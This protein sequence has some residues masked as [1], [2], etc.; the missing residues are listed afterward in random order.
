MTIR[1]TLAAAIGLSLI[2]GA[3]SAD[4]FAAY[5]GKYPADPVN[6]VGFFSHPKVEAGIKDAEGDAVYEE[7]SNLQVQ[8]PITG[9]SEV[10]VANVCRQHDCG[11]NNASVVMWRNGELA[12]ICRF[13]NNVEFWYTPFFDGALDVGPGQ[14]QPCPS[15]VGQMW[16]RVTDLGGADSM[17]RSLEM[18]VEGRARQQASIA[19]SWWMSYRHA[20]AQSATMVVS[21]PPD[22]FSFQTVSDDKRGAFFQGADGRSYI[23]AYSGFLDHNTNQTLEQAY[24]AYRNQQGRQEVEVNRPTQ[25]INYIHFSA[26][27]D[28]LIY[29]RVRED[30]NGA[31]WIWIEAQIPAQTDAATADM[32]KKITQTFKPDP[33]PVD[34]CF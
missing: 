20:P 22:R 29:G 18:R 24:Q 33:D 8:V 11:G 16:R 4:E 13:K 19:P 3:A 15:E 7:I 10:V 21:Y 17:R 32:A 2:A 27:G 28:T 30:C 26:S 5:I 14:A 23:W 34:G 1:T 31:G 25:E 9:D 12:I 6:G